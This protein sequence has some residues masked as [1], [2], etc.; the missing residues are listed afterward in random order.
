[1]KSLLDP[2]L[3]DAWGSELDDTFRYVFP[4]EA[5]WGCH[6]KI[7]Q[8]LCKDRGCNTACLSNSS[9]TFLAVAWCA[10]DEQDISPEA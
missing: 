4:Q 1:M 7:C 10:V 8:L 3:M 6:P 5:F 2:G 9:V